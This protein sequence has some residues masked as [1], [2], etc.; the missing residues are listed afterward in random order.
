MIQRHGVLLAISLFT[1]TSASD[2]FVKMADR[3]CSRGGPKFDDLITNQRYKSVADYLSE[4]SPEAV[5][6]CQ[7]ACDTNPDCVSFWIRIRRSD[8]VTWCSTSSK[9]APT[10]GIT[11]RHYPQ[12]DS[13]SFRY[14]F[15]VRESLKTLV[16][17]GG[18]SKD[19]FTYYENTVCAGFDDSERL[20]GT[21]T[22]AECANECKERPDCLSFEWQWSNSFCQM[23]K[24]CAR[25]NGIEYVTS[26]DRH[27][28]VKPSFDSFPTV[29]PAGYHH[30]TDMY[31]YTRDELMFKTKTLDACAAVCTEDN[32]CLSFEWTG[33]TGSA[34]C[35][36]SHTCAP[37]QGVEPIVKDGYDL[38]TKIHE[39]VPI[40]SFSGFTLQKGH[41]CVGRNEL[42]EGYGTGHHTSTITKCAADCRA[43]D[44][45]V[46]FEWTTLA[47]R[48][49]CL[50]S[51]TC[52]PARGVVASSTSESRSF[53]HEDLYIKNEFSAYTSE[54]QGFALQKN[55]KCNERV[56][57]S[58]DNTETLQSCAKLCEDDET[59]VSFYW[60]GRS[61]RIM[62]R[63][64]LSKSCA[65]ALGVMPSIYYDHDLYIKDGLTTYIDTTPDNYVLYKEAGCPHRTG[66]TTLHSTVAECAVACN[67]AAKCVS[68]QWNG[69]LQG[70]GSC[71]LSETCAKSHGVNPDENLHFTDL[72]VQKIHDVYPTDAPEGFELKQD[73][74]CELFDTPISVTRGVDTLISCAE[75]CQRDD[76]C[77][78]FEWDYR[79]GYDGKCSLSA[80]CAP[81]KGVV[82]RAVA[83]ISLYIKEAESKYVAEANGF[84]YISD[85]VCLGEPKRID[86][87]KETLPSCAARCA[88]SGSDC[89]SFE[90]T[91][92]AGTNMCRLNTKCSAQE[93]FD[94]RRTDKQDL[95]VKDAFAVEGSTQ[96][97]EFYTHSV[98]VP[99]GFHLQQDKICHYRNE[100]GLMTAHSNVES[101]NVCADKCRALGADCV[102]FEWSGRSVRG[103]SCWLSKTC[104]PFF[105]LV[106][107]DSDLNRDLYIKTNYTVYPE[108]APTGYTRHSDSSCGHRRGDI[109][110][111][112]YTETLQ[113]CAAKC[114]ST[115]DC[116]S[117][118]W[119]GRR[120][121]SHCFLSST[122]APAMGI[123]LDENSYGNDVYIKSDFN[124]YTTIV[125]AGYEL[126]QDRY[127]Y[128]RDELTSEDDSKNSQTLESC[129][130][131]CTATDT[132]V[133]FMWHGRKPNGRFG[134]GA[135]CVMSST[136]SPSHGVLPTVSA[137]IDLYIKATEMTYAVVTP[138]GFTHWADTICRAP[139][140]IT[141][142][143]AYI[144]F[145]ACAQE[146]ANNDLCSAIEW[147][148]QEQRTHATCMLTKNCG[149]AFDDSLQP[150][151][152]RDVFVKDAFSST[153]S[154]TPESAAG[155]HPTHGDGECVQVIRPVGWTL[156]TSCD[157]VDCR[158]WDCSEWC[159]CF[160]LVD[161]LVYARNGCGSEH[162]DG[163]SCK[164]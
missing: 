93:N 58:R 68:F 148:G 10:N 64:L 28:F 153:F 91:G 103:T 127:C 114:D 81:S 80:N 63:C 139:D 11:P 107:T 131:L 57:E 60:T 135:R 38:Y 12:K 159:R 20:E 123:S 164:C 97:S 126:Q 146:C 41:F 8:G 162:D 156:P 73:N 101:L 74:S 113:S 118:E 14:S 136:C 43:S 134:A 40:T 120:H 19:D 2:A 24:T 98:S 25:K 161:E 17:D 67:Q 137:S 71:A 42:R 3:S 33:R 45:C 34:T 102:S 23:S 13:D 47:G 15:Y 155:A 89:V 138:I 50:L 31:C 108:D 79:M 27:L 111:Y 54:V 62:S 35:I 109:R 18:V 5:A 129:A 94:Y 130:A 7:T 30:Q 92:R 44:D 152:K 140:R 100:G 144:T 55:R 69:R 4:P 21:R 1:V 141:I 145:E 48:N 160:A 105:G 83:G 122:C 119:D 132:C 157:V 76:H 46:S 143:N 36:I 53:Y 65:P 22:V 115:E 112:R 77:V 61:P 142:D 37:S 154:S 16:P 96:A 66:D 125:P 163:I 110:E 151:T 133:S 52:A 88:D 106:P 59:C 82:S 26:G 158:N 84:K 9:C 124:T 90:W 49:F 147:N 117:Y 85:H 51:S 78:A 86:N 121:G 75:N 6:D 116:V 150:R 87:E 149:N 56:D 95:Y 39:L 32:K 99:A 72:Y 70:G 128:R 104:A 29:A